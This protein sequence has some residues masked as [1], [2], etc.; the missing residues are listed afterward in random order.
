MELCPK[1]GGISFYDSYFG[2][3]ICTRC[4]WRDDSPAR[5]RELVHR[6]LYQGTPLQ[7]RRRLERLTA[8]LKEEAEVEAK[9]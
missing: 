3:Y 1:C 7:R 4:D 8:L 5:D 9:V 6:F 2:A